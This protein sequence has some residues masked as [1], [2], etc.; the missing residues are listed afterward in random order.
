M[1]IDVDAIFNQKL[2][3]IES[4]LADIPGMSTESTD[5]SDIPFQKYLANATQSGLSNSLDGS[6]DDT[7]FLSGNTSLSN[8]LGQLQDSNSANVLKARVALANS[9]AYIPTDSTELMNLINAGINSASAKYGVDKDLIRAVIKQESSFDPTSISKT[10]AEGLMQLMPGTAEG[11][12]VK[13]PF[14]ILQNIDGGTQ[15]LKDQ[16]NRFNGNV[17]LALAAYNAGP[18]S[19]EKYGGV[20]PYSETQ[21]YVKKVSDYY[22]QYKMSA[23]R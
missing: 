3:E 5:T 16:L 13:N 7:S 14:D 10:G 4:R 8:V 1:N 21:D 2:A 12:G 18:N 20:P 22:N 11:L 15:Y 17:S 19:V 9:K 6:N 23:S